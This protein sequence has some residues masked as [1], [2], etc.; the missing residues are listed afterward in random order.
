MNLIMP[1]LSWQYVGRRNV[2]LRPGFSW[3]MTKKLSDRRLCIKCDT[4][5][6]VRQN[7]NR[8]VQFTRIAD[9]SL[10]TGNFTGNGIYR[11]AMT[12]GSE[13]ALPTVSFKRCWGEGCM[14]YQ[15]T[16]PSSQLSLIRV[17]LLLFF[18]KL[19]KETIATSAKSTPIVELNYG[20]FQGNITADVE[21]FLGM[22]FAAPPYV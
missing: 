9:W 19:V 12:H 21:S 7:Y 3:L 20:S 5:L 6:V 16:M 4:L 8:F 17:G 1:Y 14:K 10:I 2:R 11:W 22:P 18:A 15:T 13:I